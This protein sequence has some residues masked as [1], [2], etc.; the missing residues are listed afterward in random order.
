MFHHTTGCLSFKGMG[1]GRGVLAGWGQGLRPLLPQPTPC[2]WHA[3]CARQGMHRQ[4]APAAPCLPQRPD[5]IMSLL[6]NVS[7][8]AC[9]G[10]LLC[11]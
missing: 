7:G 5:L 6:V 3:P 2:W 8:A 4:V 9:C 10:R 1:G 11:S